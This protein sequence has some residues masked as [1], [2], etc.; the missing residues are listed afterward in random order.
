MRPRRIERN[1]ESLAEFITERVQSHFVGQVCARPR[2]ASIGAQMLRQL[3]YIVQGFDSP[4]EFDHSARLVAVKA[5]PC[6]ALTKLI[7]KLVIAHGVGRTALSKVAG[8]LHY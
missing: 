7:A 5:A 3:A 2:G 6:S 4:Q 8:A 1:L